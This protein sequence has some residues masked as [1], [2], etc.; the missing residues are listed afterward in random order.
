MVPALGVLRIA[1]PPGLPPPYARVSGAPSVRPGHPG[2][3]RRHSPLSAAGGESGHGDARE[4]DVGDVGQRDPAPAGARDVRQRQ[5]IAGR[6]AGNF[7][8][9]TSVP[10]PLTL[11]LLNRISWNRPTVRRPRHRVARLN[12]LSRSQFR[13]TFPVDD[14]EVLSGDVLEIAAATVAAL[15]KDAVLAARDSTALEA[16]VAERWTFPCQRR[17]R[18]RCCSPALSR[19][20][21]FS[22]GQPRRSAASPRPDFSTIASSPVLMSQCST[23]T[24]GTNRR[25][26][27]RRCSRWSG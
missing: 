3:C 16:H 6:S 25:Q 24:P 2:R 5:T 18:R 14:G 1:A 27:R 4:F 12:A 22:V 7:A 11:I 26:C 17:R 21:T 9:S 8:A 23:N 10:T 19:I 15:D 20:T 13:G